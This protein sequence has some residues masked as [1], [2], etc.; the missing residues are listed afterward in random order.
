MSEKAISESGFTLKDFQLT[1]ESIKDKSTKAYGIAISKYINSTIQGGTSGYYFLRN[2]RIRQNRNAANGRVNMDKFKDLLEFNGK[3]NFANL[4]WQSI[5]IVNR[6]CSGLKGRFMNKSEK[7]QIEATDSLSVK[8]KNK[9]YDEL[10][11]LVYNKEKLEQLQ[12]QGGEQLIPQNAQIPAD[13]EELDF[14]IA[15]K[16]L[17]LPEEILFEIGINDTLSANGLFDTIKERLLDDSIIAGFVGTYVEMDENG[18]ITVQDVKP[19][20]AIYSQSYYND[21]RDTTWRGEKKSM[22]ISEL[23]KKY[24]KEFN[25]KDPLA[26]TE[27]KLFEIASTAKEY[28]LT[29]K[30]TWIASWNLMF[31]R[32]YDEWNID[33]IRFQLRT[34]DSESYTLVTTKKTTFIKN[35]STAKRQTNEQVKEDSRINIYEG[36]YL[37]NNDILLKWGMKTNMIRPQDPKEIGNAEFSYS[38]YM[39]QNYEMRNIALPEKIQAPCEAMVVATLKMQQVIA[40]CS[41]PGAAYNVDAIQEIDL[42]LASGSSSP[43]E[44]EKIRRQTGNLYY[45]G[46]DAEGN[47]IP[48]PVTELSNA[49]FLPQMNGLME[50][51][52]FNYEILKNELGE[53]P[54]LMSQA[55]Q[56]RVTEG[57]VNTAQEVA[58]NATD[59]MYDA[60]RYVMEDT[61][62]K[63]ACLLKDSVEYG[64]VVYRELIKQE[65]VKDREFGT[66]IMLLPQGQQIAKFEAMLN[67]AITTNK[68]LVKFVNP[69]QLSRVATENVK[70]AEQLFYQGTKKMLLYEDNM[71]QQNSQMNAKSQQDSLVMKAQADAKAK[72]D[73]MQMK[74]QIEMAMS[75]E[76]QAEITLSGIFNILSK[77]LPVPAEWKGVE[78]EL[79]N[80]VAL[81]LFAKNIMAGQQLDQQGQQEQQES[82]QGQQEPQG[83]EMPQEQQEQ[84]QQPQMAA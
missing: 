61:A 32:P 80:N 54:A 44:I 27:E 74:G 35:G 59:Y 12:Q 47:P 24:G 15:S 65:D 46:K 21:F 79:I 22:K 53:D 9:M 41:P 50:N 66:K 83:Q 34:V 60:Y 7:I 68:D 84:S 17:R 69:F 56:P 6:I 77:G 48:V 8:D 39:Y 37:V 38:F 52:R 4:N 1:T 42:G 81:P 71:A 29:D 14:L 55:L 75:K 73:E 11:Y 28:Q 76:R 58:E 10:E 78:S 64:S 36:I 2:E 18:V 26:L 33:Y 3:T 5:K 49:G 25:P 82:Q 40:A 62:K 20:N 72:Q 30:L 57:N 63:M 70:L 43:I 13:K 67:N 23:R 31:I 45:R 16:V 51:Y 19:E